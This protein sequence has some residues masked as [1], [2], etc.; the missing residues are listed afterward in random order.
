MTVILRSILFELARQYNIT[1][2][3]AISLHK[4]YLAN[5]TRIAL[6]DGIITDFEMKDIIQ[7]AKLLHISEDD[8]AL[9]IQ[10][11]QKN[12]VTNGVVKPE[13]KND[14]VGKSVCFTGTLTA[15]YKGNP[16]T[17]EMAQQLATEY[18]LIVKKSVTKDLDYLVT[19]DPD[20]MSGKAKKARQYN[21]KILAEQAFWTLLGLQF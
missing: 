8:L 18:G 19:A 9:I 2:P 21:T 5:V 17:R 3:Q 7:L 13:I 10:E 6:M 11:E 20:S 15:L 4:R 1:K 14:I 12:M 16:M